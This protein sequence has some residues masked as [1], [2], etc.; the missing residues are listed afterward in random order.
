[1]AE[2]VGFELT[3]LSI[4]AH[5]KKLGRNLANVKELHFLRGCKCWTQ[6]DDDLPSSGPRLDPHREP[7]ASQQRAPANKLIYSHSGRHAT[8]T[9]PPRNR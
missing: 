8:G 7:P 9:G 6:K 4:L 1:M 2:E 5:D 3:D